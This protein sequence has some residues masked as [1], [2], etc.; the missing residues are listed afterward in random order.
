MSRRAAAVKEP[1]PIN[2]NDVSE[3]RVLGYAEGITPVTEKGSIVIWTSSYEGILNNYQVKLDPKFNLRAL[4]EFVKVVSVYNKN[5][6]QIIFFVVRKGDEEFYTPVSME[7]IRDNFEICQSKFR[8]DSDCIVLF[9]KG[10]KRFAFFNC[11]ADNFSDEASERVSAVVFCPY[12]GLV[13]NIIYGVENKGKAEIGKNVARVYLKKKPEVRKNKKSPFSDKEN[14]MDDWWEFCTKE[15]YLKGVMEDNG[16]FICENSIMDLEKKIAKKL[17]NNPP[18]VSFKVGDIEITVLKPEDGNLTIDYIK[19]LLGEQIYYKKID[20][21]NIAIRKEEYD[22]FCKSNFDIDFVARQSPTQPVNI[23]AAGSVAEV[24][25]AVLSKSIEENNKAE[26]QRIVS[27]FKLDSQVQTDHAELLR[28]IGVTNPDLNLNIIIE[29]MRDNSFIFNRN[30][31]DNG[32][33][34]HLFYIVDTSAHNRKNFVKIFLKIMDAFGLYPYLLY[35]KMFDTQRVI[36][37]YKLFKEC[38]E[39]RSNNDLGVNKYSK[40]RRELFDYLMNSLEQGYSYP[41]DDLEKIQ[42]YLKTLTEFSQDCDK[43]II[44]FGKF[45]CENLIEVAIKTNNVAFL[46]ILLD[47]L[48]KEERDNNR[49]GLVDIYGEE[50]LANNHLIKLAFNNNASKDIFLLLLEQNF[51]DKSLSDNKFSDVFHVLSR[52]DEL[53]ELF[54]AVMEEYAFR[55]DNFLI[56]DSLHNGFFVE[57]LISLAHENNELLTRLVIYYCEK[58]AP[59]NLSLLFDQEFYTTNILPIIE[60]HKREVLDSAFFVI[61]QELHTA[62]TDL[63]KLQEETSILAGKLEAN[64]DA[65]QKS[66]SELLNSQGYVTRLKSEF[67]VQESQYIQE[68]KNITEKLEAKKAELRRLQEEQE[69]LKNNY[70]RDVDIKQEMAAKIEKSNKDLLNLREK[71]SNSQQKNDQL[72]LR[73]KQEQEA[74]TRKVESLEQENAALKE[75]AAA[76][77]KQQQIKEEQER[78]RREVEEQSSQVQLKQFLESYSRLENISDLPPFLRTRV[79]KLFSTFGSENVTVILKGSA[80]WQTEESFMVRAPA[81]LDVEIIINGLEGF[82]D[83]KRRKLLAIL[84]GLAV[85]DQNLPIFKAYTNETDYTLNFSCEEGLLDFTL[86]DADKQPEN[87]LSWNTNVENRLEVSLNDDCELSCKRI[88]GRGIDVA[89]PYAREYNPLPV[90]PSEFIINPESHGLIMRLALLKTIAR[91]SDEDINSQLTTHRINV[92]ELL[93]DEFKLRNVE[94]SDITAEIAQKINDYCKKHNLNSLEKAFAQNL[95]LIV[96][97]HS[98]ERLTE[99][100]EKILEVLEQYQSPKSPAKAQ[101]QKLKPQQAAYIKPPS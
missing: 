37:S 64:E 71:F 86:Y 34:N 49:I 101:G 42:S 53:P 70:Q 92:F 13:Y 56:N 47:R 41:Q 88:K 28:L 98:P 44:E 16:Y 79:K 4:S 66:R 94:T 52:S 85:D 8:E 78:Q 9:A 10:S 72:E 51:V 15:E 84:S 46:K 33:G 89:N 39:Q 23:G 32:S 91:V 60:A 5:G 38:N 58:S 55:E 87:Q 18:Q 21:K 29:V 93:L 36:E 77:N 68:I 100:G 99:K 63:E 69:T 75:Q 35:L 82:D 74:L 67:T 17:T 40:A 26:A 14:K 6:K 7:T 20:G 1:N 27:A 19:S 50:L 73:A 48:K 59:N 80:V 12:N 31:Y 95:Q 61:S 3:V 54:N 57:K 25:G 43:E 45:S 30:I 2:F 65:L 76:I 62:K 81:D 22:Q 97:H 11:Q 90:S 83:A 24:L 96:R